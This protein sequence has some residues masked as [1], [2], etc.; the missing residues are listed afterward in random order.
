M[1]ALSTHTTKELQL[2]GDK[3]ARPHIEAYP[4]TPLRT[5]TP[6]FG[7]PRCK[8]LAPPLFFGETDSTIV[9][10]ICKGAVLT[11]QA[12]PPS[13]IFAHLMQGR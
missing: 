7:P 1:L 8:H 11:M 6:D 4:R 3:V 12:R 10:R 13:L 5:L 9:I 2:L